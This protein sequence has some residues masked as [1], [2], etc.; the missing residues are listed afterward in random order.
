MAGQNVPDRRI[1][2]PQYPRTEPLQTA[3][4]HQVITVAESM[5]IGEENPLAYVVA[6]EPR[7]RC[8]IDRVPLDL[9]AVSLRQIRG[10]EG[11]SMLSS[12]AARVA[13]ATI[14]LLSCAP[15]PSS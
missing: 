12:F 13:G 6:V 5:L 15:N 9:A 7:P 11:G 2:L 1:F 3:L 8:A 4:A 14:P 10:R